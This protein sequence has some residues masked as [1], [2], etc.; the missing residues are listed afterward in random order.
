[1]FNVPL[2]DTTDTVEEVVVVDD[3]MF[4]LVDELDVVSEVEV[5]DVVG[6]DVE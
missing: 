1:M 3:G 6:E 5:V 2:R 4:E